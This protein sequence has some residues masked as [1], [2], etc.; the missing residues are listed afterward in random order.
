MPPANESRVRIRR[1]RSILLV[2][3]SSILAAWM[4]EA[5]SIS[6]RARPFLYDDVALIPKRHVGLLLGC[7]E[8]LRDGKPNPFFVSRIDAA[9][10][11]F[12]HGKIDYILAS[13]ENSSPSYNEPAR[14]RA[15]LTARGVPS[16]RI[17]AD[18][19]GFRTLDS[20][21]RAH[22]V[23]GLGSYTVISQRFHN[24]RAVYFAEGFGGQ[25]IGFNAADVP[26]GPRMLYR[27]TV[28]RLGAALRVH[29]L[30]SHPRYL[31]PAVSIGDEGFSSPEPSHR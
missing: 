24:E 3:G 8:R 7:S 10:R 21:V 17:V 12:E 22:E 16:T 27:D 5:L 2:T 30:H 25:A 20:V 13:G 23:F 29:V 28:A 31:G 14:M 15:A 1:L 18:Y 19:A 4:G 9:V 6:L 11:L 26:R